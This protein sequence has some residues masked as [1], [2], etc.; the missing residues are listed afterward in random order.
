MKYKEFLG[1]KP[2]NGVEYML[3]SDHKTGLEGPAA[4]S[5]PLPYLYSAL[6]KYIKLFRLV[7]FILYTLAGLVDLLALYS[8]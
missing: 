6:G 8:L 1:M 2:A 3:V 7:P 4:V 5:F